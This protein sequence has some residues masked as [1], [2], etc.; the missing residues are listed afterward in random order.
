MF[1]EIHFFSTSAEP[2]FMQYFVLESAVNSLYPTKYCLK[3][4]SMEVL[5][6]NSF[7]RTVRFFHPP[8]ISLQRK[9][10]CS[11]QKLIFLL[12]HWTENE[13][14]FHGSSGI[15]CETFCWTPWKN[16]FP[17]SERTKKSANFWVPL[18]SSIVQNNSVGR[19]ERNGRRVG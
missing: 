6:K 10:K 5:E 14:S 2:I 16:R 13:N 15:V 7:P 11:I 9:Q 4:S 12:V 1:C 8:C 19:R 3:I 17:V 18:R